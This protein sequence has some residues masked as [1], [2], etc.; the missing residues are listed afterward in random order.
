L[1][2]KVFGTF[3]TKKVQETNVEKSIRGTQNPCTFIGYRQIKFR[4]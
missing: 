1:L 3:L 4:N 2:E